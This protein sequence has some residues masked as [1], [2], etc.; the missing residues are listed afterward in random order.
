MTLSD[1][2]YKH[3]RVSL[4]LPAGEVELHI[5]GREPGVAWD[6]V[7]LTPNANMRPK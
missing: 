1:E 3:D 2:E 6:K 7:M 4:L 5:Y